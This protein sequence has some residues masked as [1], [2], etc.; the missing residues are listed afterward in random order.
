[1]DLYVEN[2]LI[3]L[4][5]TNSRAKNMFNI[6]TIVNTNENINSHYNV[7]RNIYVRDKLN[8]INYH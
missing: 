5:T 8:H 7:H 6:Q 2:I 4:F 3:L 1:M